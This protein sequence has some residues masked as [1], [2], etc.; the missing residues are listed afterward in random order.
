MGGYEGITRVGK[1]RDADSTR[2]SK[3]EHSASRGGRI[4]VDLNDA[5]TNVICDVVV[6]ACFDGK[7]QYVCHFSNVCHG[8][9]H[10]L[11]SWVD[12]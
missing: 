2:A 9:S 3:G 6:A 5:A 4:H 1:T 7:K 11:S 12:A 10:V 8:V